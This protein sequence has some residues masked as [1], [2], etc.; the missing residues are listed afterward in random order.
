MD[1][2][3]RRNDIEAYGPTIQPMVGLRRKATAAVKER[4]NECQVD[5]RTADGG[6]TGITS[7]L[8]AT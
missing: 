1:G 4:R 8:K 7:K 3:L 5:T 6:V 2:M